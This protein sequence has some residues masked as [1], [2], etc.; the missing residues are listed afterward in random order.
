MNLAWSDLDDALVMA[1][2]MSSKTIGWCKFNPVMNMVA[3][4]HSL[5]MLQKQNTN[6]HYENVRQYYLGNLFGLD[7]RELQAGLEGWQLEPVQAAQLIVKTWGDCYG[8]AWMLRAFDIR[9][10]GLGLVYGNGKWY[11]TLLT[12]FTP[13]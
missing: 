6:G 3:K 9:S 12:G 13:K 8:S 4:R 2:K 7:V 11:S 5:Y 10:A 1:L